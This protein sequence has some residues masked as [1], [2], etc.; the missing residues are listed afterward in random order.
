[1]HKVI[2]LDRDGTLIEDTGYISN[3]SKISV[4]LGVFEGLSMLMEAGFKFVII[5]NQSGVARKLIS[6]SEFE[7]V[8]R[9]F[10][11]LF[12]NQ[13]IGFESIYYCFHL[14]TDNCTC[15]KPGIDFFNQAKVKMKSGYFAAMVGDSTVD[16]LFA[17]NC[18]ISFYTTCKISGHQRYPNFKVI[19]QAIL[20]EIASAE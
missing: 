15:R 7:E 13:A 18:G 16:A 17:Q 10:V 14:P 4:K 19:A 1:M 20:G 5:S 6:A 9:A 12:A 2:F 8:N 3:P 11:K